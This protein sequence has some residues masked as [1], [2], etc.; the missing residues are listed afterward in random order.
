MF[1]HPGP[2]LPR[3]MGVASSTR[4]PS[5]ACNGVPKATGFFLSN[6]SAKDARQLQ[7]KSRIVGI[8]SLVIVACSP[9][10]V[11]AGLILSVDYEDGTFGNVSRTSATTTTG[12]SSL[13]CAHSAQI[14]TTPVSAGNRAVKMTLLPADQ[15]YEYGKYKDP[16]VRA[17]FEK[18]TVS[19]VGDQRW[20]GFS[21][22]VD[23]SYTDTSTDPN[24]TILFQWHTNTDACDQ[25][26]SPHLALL[27]TKDN[28]WRVENRSD[29]N[30]CTIVNPASERTFLRVNW[31]LGPTTKGVWVNWVI[32]AKWSFGTTGELKVWKDGTLVINR[33]GPNA[34]N[35]QSPEFIKWGVYK[36]WW[37]LQPAPAS[38]RL[39][40]Y[41][42][43]IKVGDANSSYAEIAPKSSLPIGI[44]IPAAPINL[45]LITK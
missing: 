25:S 41:L 17:E 3:G 1:V 44:N 28:R 4:R 11:H 30:A 35:D 26:K 13:C 22:Y 8:I 27:V 14:V 18:W 5:G 2:L 16:Y 45:Q 21:T 34:Y 6:H 36:S 32:Y 15:G 23:P 43:E 37:G 24:G 10:A 31:D 40:V 12:Y 38:D 7:M 42:D 20:Y 29:P 9:L 19:H 33:T 39:I